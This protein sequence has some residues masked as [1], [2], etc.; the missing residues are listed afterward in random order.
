M[1]Y[2]R[3]SSTLFLL[4][5]L[6]YAHKSHQDGEASG[7]SEE[8]AVQE[9][10][11]AQADSHFTFDDTILYKINWIDESPSESNKSSTDSDDQVCGDKNQLLMYL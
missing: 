8:N 4:L 5:L 1:A 2:H 6:T 7:L 11:I 10:A 9:N 3:R